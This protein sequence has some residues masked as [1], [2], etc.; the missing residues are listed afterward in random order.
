MP[1]S[2]TAGLSARNLTKYERMAERTARRFLSGMALDHQQE[3]LNSPEFRSH[4]SAESLRRHQTRVAR[5]LA[6]RQRQVEALRMPCR[7]RRCLKARGK[8]FPSYYVINRL[9]YECHLERQQI[10][11]EL[12]EILATLRNDRAR[13]GSVVIAR[14]VK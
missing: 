7:C 12:E 1:D 10:D 2:P 9:S 6:Q 4:L 14:G 8:P 5:E 3:L 11:P 13:V